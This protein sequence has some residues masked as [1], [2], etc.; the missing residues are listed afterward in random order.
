MKDLHDLFVHELQAMYDAERQIIQALPLVID[1]VNSTALKTALKDHL[2]ETEEQARRLEDILQELGKNTTQVICKPMEILLKE[3]EKIIQSD[4]EQ[5]VKEAALINCAQHVEHFE[6]ASYG[7][8]KA[9][10][11]KFKYD[12]FL[13]LLEESSEEEGN[14]DKKLTK[15]AEGTLFVKGINEKAKKDA[16]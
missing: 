15:V 12:E 5:E 11:K 10:A 3:A 14:A 16:A 13:A 4:Y 6:I 1:A 7:T 9:L 2:Q 8:L